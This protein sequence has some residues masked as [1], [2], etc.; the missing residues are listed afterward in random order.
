MAEEITSLPGDALI[1]VLS[2]L[3]TF[4]DVATCFASCRTFFECRDDPILWKNLC[5]SL[6]PFYARCSF[7]RDSGEVLQWK[8]ICQTFGNPSVT[9]NSPIVIW[10]QMAPPQQISNHETSMEARVTIFNAD[11]VHPIKLSVGYQFMYWKRVDLA[12]GKFLFCGEKAFHQIHPR[13]FLRGGT[14]AP[15]GRAVRE[16]TTTLDPGGRF[17]FDPFEL[18]YSRHRLE[19][20]LEA[21][22]GSQYYHLR[23][24]LPNASRRGPFQIRWATRWKKEGDRRE[25]D[26]D[27]GIYCSNP[28]PWESAMQPSGIF[29]EKA[30]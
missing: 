18:I 16:I 30:D 23:S 17:D 10:L 13:A 29:K 11:K 12:T 28:V 14:L 26:D 27:G 2:F 25:G 21:G 5:H 9:K 20:F 4:C 22:V 24:T 15:G 8:E 7:R 6:L 1:A 3:P 19:S